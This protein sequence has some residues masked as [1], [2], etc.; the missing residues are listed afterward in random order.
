[1]AG[2]HLK[3]L[4][5]E[6]IKVGSVFVNVAQIKRGVSVTLEV[7]KGLKTQ[8]EVNAGH[9]RPTEILPGVS[10]RCEGFD[11]PYR[12]ALEFH[13]SLNTKIERLSHEADSVRF[14]GGVHPAIA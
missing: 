11:R 9:P 7:E 4:Q 10:V 5:G 1:M 8:I 3:L 12:V 13:A 2:L 6:R 14:V